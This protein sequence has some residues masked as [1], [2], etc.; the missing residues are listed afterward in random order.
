MRA[1]QRIQDF[2]PALD[3]VGATASLM[4][5]I[6]CL[7]MPVLL[8]VLPTLGLGFLLN[9]SL[10]R[11]FVIGSVVLAVAN[12][13]WGFRVHRKSRVVWCAT[14]G[15][16]FLLCA[17]FGHSHQT[18]SAHMHHDHAGHDHGQYQEEHPQSTWGGL[19]LLLGGAAFITSAHL[20]NRRFCKSCSHCEHDHA[21]S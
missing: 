18:E 3:T 14:I 17:T 1:A 20:L 11:G 12:T 13:C 8:V 6:H 16:V 10:E 4:C 15:G 21:A 9:E 5:A 19:A 7:A 2:F